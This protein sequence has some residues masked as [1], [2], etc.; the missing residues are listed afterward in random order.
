MSIDAVAAS[1]V[2]GRKPRG[3]PPDCY[4]FRSLSGPHAQVYGS[5]VHGYAALLRDRAFGSREHGIYDRVATATRKLIV[6]YATG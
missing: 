4:A 6:G 2:E 3:W 5:L 1:V